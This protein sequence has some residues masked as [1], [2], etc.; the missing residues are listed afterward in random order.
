MRIKI[1]L[2]IFSLIWVALLVR[3]FYLSVQ[4]NAYYDA[5]SDN[6]TI[7]SEL[8]TPIRGN[9][10][11]RNGNPIA[12]NKLGFKIVLEPHLSD[13]SERKILE[14]ELQTLISYLPSLDYDDM[15]KRYLKK[16]SYYNHHFISIADFIS[17]E[18]ILPVF[19]FLN[20]REKIKILPASQ[21]YY[22]YGKI[23]AHMIG[24]V[25][26]ASKKDVE[27][28]PLLKL[29]G[30]VGKSGIEKQYNRYLQ[31]NPGERLIKVSAYNEEIEEISNTPPDENHRL[32]LNL[33]MRLQE[34][35]SKLFE[36]LAG[37]VV[38]MS[39]DGAVLAA[40]SYPE[41]DLN[42]FATGITTEAWHDL[43]NDID[44]PF[45]NKITNGLYPPG[46]VIK[47]GMGLIFISSEL[48][49]WSKFFCTGT[50]EF[51]K[52]NFRCWKHTG[53]GETDI[54]KAI[55]ES[56]DDYFYKGSLKVGIATMSE[57]LEA[58]GLGD[59]T[60]IDIPNEF[61]GTVPSRIWKRKRYNQPWYIGETLNTS[62]G[63][64]SFLV[65]PLQVTQFTAL[66][67]TGKLPIPRVAR[68]LG[69]TPVPAESKSV[70]TAREKHNLPHI[71]H[72]MAE[73]CNHPMGTASG[74]I[75]SQ[76]TLAGKTGTAQVIGISQ[77]TKKRLKEHEME[78]Y[79]RSH[80]WLATYGPVKNPQYVVT[81]L[82][83]HGGH[84]G[85][86]AGGITSRIFDKLLEYG[87]ITN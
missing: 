49:P 69:D 27:E 13:P 17:Y 53:H 83:E 23:A 65:T 16:D 2:L 18:E 37:A 43:I 55:R 30:Y 14:E 85:Q 41:Y 57:R 36:G 8:I 15:L 58:F 56:C 86:A 25:S 77:E 75:D 47:P 66:M 87:Y 48:Q 59:K 73:V 51:G 26:R 9:I 35:I 34:D 19:S 32:T 5:L 80:A 45:T 22:P 44:T 81:V 33:D 20:L 31:G 67:A 3:I 79:Q 82:V 29:I 54:N 6:N 39:T 61:I 60:G 62:I 72:A 1:I 76:V 68:L 11:D 21:R 40:G 71:Q 24:Y 74:Y 10:F 70:L 63:Q 42:T 64:G 28:D 50:M 4:S 78:Y 38:V 52:R 12:I 7:K 84:G 46:S